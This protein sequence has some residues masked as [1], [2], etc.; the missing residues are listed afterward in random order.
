VQESRAFQVRPFIAQMPQ[1]ILGESLFG[2]ISRGLSR[3][4][5]SQV[6]SAFKLGTGRGKQTPRPFNVTTEESDG[7]ARLFKVDP[8]EFRSRLYQ[9]GKFEHSPSVSIDFFGT[10][11]RLQYLET[12]IRRISPRSLSESSHHK[13][14][15]DLRP[16]SFD[17]DTWERLLDCC[18]VCKKQLGWSS[19]YGPSKC[20]KCVDAAG[21]PTDLRKFKQPLIEVLD[22]EAL[23]FV[24]GLVHPDLEKRASAMRL[25]PRELNSATSSDLFEAVVSIAYALVPAHSNRRM[26]GRPFTVEE[27][28]QVTPDRLAL[29]ARAVIGGET[30][31]ARVADA[32]R[33]SMGQRSATFGRFK[34]LGPISALVHDTELAPAIRSF[35]E[36]AIERDL[37]RTAGLGLVRSRF[38]QRSRSENDT[39]RGVKEL[40]AETGL[41][42]SALKRLAESGHVATRKS[43]GIR[44]PIQMNLTDIVP[45][46]ASYKDALSKPR[47][48]S[49]L[50]VPLG[51]VD[52]LAD[53]GVITRFAGAAAAM[54]GDRVYF[55]RSS[56]ESL[57][58]SII[59]RARRSRPTPMSKPLLSAVDFFRPSIPWAKIISILS[60]GEIAIESSKEKSND[61]RRNI[62]VKNQSEL[63]QRASGLK[64]CRNEEWLTTEQVMQILRVKNRTVVQRMSEAGL[65]HRRPQRRHWVY[66][67]DH[68]EMVAKQYICQP[69]MLE[70]SKFRACHSMNRWL[71]TYGVEP[72]LRHPDHG[73]IV[74]NRE[75]FECALSRCASDLKALQPKNHRR[76]TREEKKRIVDVVESGTPIIFVSRAIGSNTRTI[77]KMIEEYRSNDLKTA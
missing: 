61:W 4:L 7:L 69:E 52:E 1:P 32:M 70:K 6:Y 57:L 18:P 19:V 36:V 47:A 60:K 9:S 62:A 16:L 30:G 54:P 41:P 37:S 56:I 63:V 38:S 42:F 35:A 14:L 67:R 40:S 71:A 76:C 10:K 26:A 24:V 21:R 75:E 8:S 2:Y 15:W 45:L 22:K 66:Q 28:V 64:R 49:L 73:A 23:S 50:K 20:D 68:V 29:A 27:F 43:E 48:A 31:F 74:Y 3:T 17:P 11:I 39:W 51:D 33:E 5:C 25:V 46:V 13:A 58:E 59:E 34:E 53:E 12:K 44:G 65:V 55:S 77:E 72:V